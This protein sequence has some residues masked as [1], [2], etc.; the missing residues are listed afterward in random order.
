M[1][2]ALGESLS[3]FAKDDIMS[4]ES[5]EEIVSFAIEKEKE[6]V[7]YYQECALQESFAGAKDSLLEMSKE[8]QKHQAMLENLDENKEALKEYEF[9]W[10]PDIKR[11]DYMV[12]M[13]YE[14]GMHYTDI[15]RIAMKREE[16]ALKLYNELLKKTDN[17]DHV[18]VFKM[19][20]QEEAKH[21]LFLET[22]YDDY[23]AEQ[24]D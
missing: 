4:F 11:S 23:M 20:C 24:G 12:E 3:Q 21:K 19:L 6:A 22:L 15:L 9:K 18:K 17:P 7:A 13:Q 2:R 16:A 14:K 5:F 10:I 1:S 8:E